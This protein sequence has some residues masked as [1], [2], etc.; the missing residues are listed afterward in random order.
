M[1]QQVHQG[2]CS[3]GAVRYEAFGDLRPVIYCHCGQCRRQSG[4]FLGATEVP[5]A[6]LT[7]TAGADDLTWYQSSDKARRGFC[8][9]CGSGLFWKHDRQDS[10]SILAGSFDLPSGLKEGYHIFVE[11]KGDYYAI[12]DGLPQHQRWEE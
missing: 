11:H 1:S 7:V 9:I 10:T 5:D 2:G 6:N 4:H 3:C 12:D 8:R